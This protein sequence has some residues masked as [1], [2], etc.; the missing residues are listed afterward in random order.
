MNEAQ[1]LAKIDYLTLLLW[2]FVILS[3]I[4]ICLSLY[5]Y[6]K[7]RWRIKTG[8]EFDKE[9]VETRLTTL[10]KHDNWQYQEIQKISKGID[11]IKDNLVQK[12]ISDIRWE[13]LNFCSALT[14]GQDYNKEAFEHIFRTYEQYEKILADNHMSNGY[15]VESMK[16]V[17]EI[18]HNKLV[19]GD[20]N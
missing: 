17:R 8:K 5:D 11:D 12:E 19:N 15:I 9:T 10:E 1:A 20:F 14:G 7:K 6:Y 2:V 4:K 13:L 16:V 18:Y 3:F